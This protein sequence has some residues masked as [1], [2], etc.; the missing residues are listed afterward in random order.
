MRGEIL[1]FATALLAAAGILLW[2]RWREAQPGRPEA[3][4]RAA[5][6]TGAAGGGLRRGGNRQKRSLA[7]GEAAEARLAEEAARLEAAARRYGA[8]LA[9]GPPLPVPAAPAGACPAPWLHHLAGGV[10]W[11][12]LL[13]ILVEAAGLGV[14]TLAGR[15]VRGAGL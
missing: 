5:D 3:P 13:G 12:L 15:A 10:K 14:L 7:L 8:A 11:G 4:L 2:Q 1:W 9:A 6:G